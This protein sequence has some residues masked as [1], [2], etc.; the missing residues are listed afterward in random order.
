MYGKHTL[1][2]QWFSYSTEATMS[3]QKLPSMLE[4]INSFSV[5]SVTSLPFPSL[6]PL[7]MFVKSNFSFS[8]SLSVFFFIHFHFD[9]FIKITDSIFSSELIK[10][11][12]S[13]L[14]LSCRRIRP[15]M[16]R[17]LLMSFFF[18]GLTGYVR[19]I[20]LLFIY[21]ANLTSYYY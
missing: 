8:L 3:L 16:T 1:A 15:P 14:V 6:P 10:T 9:L 5:S 18:L 2:W 17:Q 11:R 21:D 19:I 20:M 13:C 4:S 12:H 7:P